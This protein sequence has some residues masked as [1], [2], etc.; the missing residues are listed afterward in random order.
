MSNAFIFFIFFPCVY[1]K[2]Y[3]ENIDVFFIGSVKIQSTEKYKSMKKATVISQ[4]VMLNLY[5]RDNHQIL[6][7]FS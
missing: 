5:T 4:I 7:T 2:I 3:Y 1:H 6:T